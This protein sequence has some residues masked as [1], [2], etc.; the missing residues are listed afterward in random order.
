MS[1]ISD[2]FSTGVDKAIDSTMNGLDNLFTSKEEKLLLRNELQKAM[3]N[4]KTEMEAENTKQ[5]TLQK[6]ILLAEIGGENWL[7]RNWRPIAMLSFTFMLVNN[8][9]LVPYGI[10]FGLGIPLVEINDGVFSMLE[11]GFGGYIASLG[12]AKMISSSKWAKKEK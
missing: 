4:L 12:G 7:M 11:L 1:W 6:E 2:I 3:N 10:A 8:Y 5:M 9:V